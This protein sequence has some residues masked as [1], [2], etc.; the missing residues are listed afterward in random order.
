MDRVAG[1][2]GAARRIEDGALDEGSLGELAASLGISE[3]QL[4][5]AVRAEFGVSP[6]ALAQTHRLLAAKRMIADTSL[7]LGEIALASGFGSLRRFH[8]LFRARYG[9]SP[10]AMRRASPRTDGTIVAEVAYRPPLGFDPHLRFFGA[11]G[12]PGVETVEEGVYRRTARIGGAAGWVAVRRHPARPSLAVEA[13]A[14]LASKLPGVLTRVR[15]LF[16]LS[17]DPDWT[18]EGGLRAP[19]AFDG[20]EASVVALL[21]LQETGAFAARFGDASPAGTL[22]PHPEAVADL[23]R[24]V[25]GGEVRL[26]PGTEVGAALERLLAIP[27]FSPSAGE[28]VAM[29]ALG[30]PDAFPAEALGLQV[31]DH[32]AVEARRPW[33]AYAAMRLWN[34]R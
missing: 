15:R 17:C 12:V 31:F 4:R 18:S 14:S 29:R 20:F 3:R 33:R 10:G 30:W 13:S 24:E 28:L 8:A 19:G 21:G 7:P 5:R 22:F 1:R 23:A 27:G 25:A 16:D 9:L 26:T 6:V 11:W 32:A 2:A 34:E